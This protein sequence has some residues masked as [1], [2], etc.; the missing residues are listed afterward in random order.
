MSLDL[1]EARR[2]V[3]FFENGL[4]G[5][6]DTDGSILYPATHAY[7]GKCKDH[8]LFLETNGNY[9]RMSPGCTE[10][11]YMQKKERPYVKNGKVGF[12]DGR[13]I[14]IPAEY[15]YIRSTF[16]DNTVFT[17]VKDGREYYIDDK[18]KEVLTRIRRFDGERSDRHSPFW[19]R[20]NSFDYFTIMNYIG[21]E[22]EGNPNV[23]K[24]YGD[25]I[26]LDRYCKDEVLKMLINPTDDLALNQN[27]LKELC[28]DFSYEY[29]FYIA[30]ATGMNP[31]SQC[32]DQLEKMHAFDN[33]W[34]FITKIWQAPGENVSAEELRSF[35]KRIYHEHMVIGK[36]LFAVGHDESLKAGEVK[37]LLVT[38]YNERCFPSDF[39]FEWSDKCKELPIQELQK[40]VPELR[41]TIEEDIRP[42]YIEQV[43]FDQIWSCVED[44]KYFEGSDWE[45]TEDALDY[46]LSQGSLIKKAAF[47]YASNAYQAMKE[48][49]FRK[50]EYYLKAALWALGKGSDFN[51]TCNSSSVIGFVKQ[52]KEEAIEERLSELVDQLL[53][54]LLSLG[55]KT[56]LEQ[57]EERDSNR[58]YWK[59]LQ[60]LN[61]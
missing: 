12:K 1:D 47:N 41:K 39:E 50:A 60:Y 16:G 49:H 33:S 21:H 53:A 51:Y 8:V 5:M 3:I 46:F 55:A 15:D 37:V 32:M 17:V 40:H 44:L 54:Q 34:Y 27:S 35:E 57:R 58:D 25:W 13:K 43:Y 7:I 9:C 10:S 29:S 61:K 48:K 18:G 14:I 42:Q 11:G 36:P 23:V 26:E 19:L 31:L 52:M 20:T 4:F 56:A 30:N 45:V 2:G 24:I 28:D 59:E 22:D 6:K 38:H